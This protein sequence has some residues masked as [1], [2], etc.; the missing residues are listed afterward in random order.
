MR[1]PDYPTAKE[2][3]ISPEGLQK[4]MSTPRDPKYPGRDVL[5]TTDMS[6]ELPI[7]LGTSGVSSLCPSTLIDEFRKSV[8]AYGLR[9]ALSV[10]I[11][12][13]RVLII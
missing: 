8:S 11:N 3:Y 1:L 12:G 2:Y 7:R 10:K 5:W 9:S 4:L 6:T 13:M